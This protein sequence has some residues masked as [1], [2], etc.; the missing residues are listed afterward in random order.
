MADTIDTTPLFKPYGGTIPPCGV[1]CGGCPVY[2][3]ERKP[4]PGAEVSQRCVQKGCRFHLCAQK[5]EVERC[6]QCDE[7]PCRRL[8]TFAGSWRK[9]GQDLLENQRL[10]SE[11]G[12]EGFLA[13][14][15][16]KV[17]DGE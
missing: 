15:N 1:Y 11:R 2:V 16:Q 9:Y 6:H 8:R 13:W 10:L 14:Y 17:Q 12:V 3:R 4:C 7:Y 5:K